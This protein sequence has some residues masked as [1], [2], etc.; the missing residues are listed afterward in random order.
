MTAAKLCVRAAL[1][2]YEGFQKGN[3]YSHIADK[4]TMAVC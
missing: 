2:A 4:E 1:P 3:R